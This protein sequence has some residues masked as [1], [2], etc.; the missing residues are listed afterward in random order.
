[1]SGMKVWTALYDRRRHPLRQESATDLH[2]GRR[3]RKLLLHN[4]TSRHCGIPQNPKRNDSPVSQ[5]YRFTEFVCTFP[6]KWNEVP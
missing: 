1:M 4:G 6:V 5:S 2:P 3:R